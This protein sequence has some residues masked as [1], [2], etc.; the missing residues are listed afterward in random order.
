MWSLATM[1]GWLDNA[2]N[3]TAQRFLQRSYIERVS[4]KRR[5]IPF[6]S[7]N[8]I[9]FSWFIG[10]PLLKSLTWRILQVEHEVSELQLPVQDGVG[11]AWILLPHLAPLVTGHL[12]RTRVTELSVQEVQEWAVG[13]LS[14]GLRN[15]KLGQIDTEL[16][17]LERMD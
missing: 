10:N 8:D 2:N 16:L 11:V 7:F 1:T 13:W 17:E 4:G 14:C 3:N 9:Y 6:P 5:N 15:I 12:T